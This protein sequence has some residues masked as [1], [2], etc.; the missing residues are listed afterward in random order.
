MTIV[1]K[2][3]TIVTADLTYKADVLV[4]QGKIVEI[5]QGLKGDRTLDA[6]GCY[7][8]PGGIDPHTHL[9][10][11]FMG[12][13]S[14][15]DFESGTRAALAGGTTMVVDFVLPGQGQGLMDAG[16]M[17]HNKSGRGT[18][19]YSYNMEVTLWG[20]KVWEDME[21]SV[22]AGMTSFKHFMAYKGALMVNDDEMYQSFKR[23]GDLGGLAMVHAE[24]GD[25]VAER[26]AK[27]LA[28]GNTGPEAHAYSRPPQV[29]G[30]ATNLS[31][32]HI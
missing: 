13:Y 23:V 16:Q 27:L 21:L 4:D 7:V 32:I 20:Q 24:N 15:D 31:L 18:C 2:N 3:G 14:A 19:G 26:T 12:T 8:M 10:M 28:E 30:E 29:E 5:G 22:K 1:I 17:W 11:P 6:S 9:E 25:V